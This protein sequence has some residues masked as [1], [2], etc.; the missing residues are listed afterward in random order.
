MS[1]RTKK[2]IKQAYKICPSYL[3]RAKFCKPVGFDDPV[4]RFCMY[5]TEA[6]SVKETFVNEKTLESQDQ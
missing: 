2:K 3:R 6:T 5:I 1:R 4:V